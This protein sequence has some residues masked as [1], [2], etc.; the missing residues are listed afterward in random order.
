MNYD[1]SIDAYE[2]CGEHVVDAF[3]GYLSWTPEEERFLENLFYGC[4]F[5]TGVSTSGIDKGSIAKM[6]G[7]TSDAITGRLHALKKER[8]P[9]Q[10]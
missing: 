3:R 9:E 10:A 2:N 4:D 7:R 6:L 5:G 1:K 8:A